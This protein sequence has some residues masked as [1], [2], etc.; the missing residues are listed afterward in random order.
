ML[1]QE[2]TARR[3]LIPGRRPIRHHPDLP[4]PNMLRP[5]LGFA[6]FAAAWLMPAE[7]APN[8]IYILADDLGYGDLGC[9][10]QQK[11]STPNIDRLAREGMRFTSFYAGNTVCAPSRS[12]LLTGQHTGHTSIRGNAEVMP[13]GQE[14]LPADTLTI[15]EVLRPAGYTSGAFGKWGLGFV[16]TEGDPQAQGFDRFF[17]YNCQRFAHRYFPPYLWD[18][19]RQVFLPGNDM[20]S[21]TTYAPDVLHDEMLGFIRTHAS[22][23]FFLFVATPIPHAELAAP[24]DEILAQFKGKFPEVPFPGWNGVWGGEAAY[25]PNAAPGGY[26]PQA[27]PRATFAAMVTR[28]DRQVGDLLRLLDELGIAD[29]TLV[30]FTSDNGPHVEGGHEESFFDSNGPFRGH[31]RDMYEG[32]IRVPMIARW[33]GRIAAGRIVD[34]PFAAWDIL[35]TLS[36][37]AGV[38]P[39]VGVDGLSM[40]P[41]LL[42]RPGQQRHEYLYWE[43]SEGRPVQAVRAGDWKAIHTFADKE[44]PARTELYNLAADPGETTN[45]AAEEPLVT[46]RLRRYMAEAHRFNARFPLPIDR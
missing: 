8:I 27:T 26:A 2:P 44:R 30:I 11:F 16:G 31:K 43:F 19:T 1:L 17:G 40:V 38:N 41:I 35:P 28:L 24:D 22:G 36:E 12:A 45:L 33:P 21:T 46:E 13:E 5:F 23:P 18:G 25:G 7:G 34:Q 29:N 37:L 32:G 14:P 15:P 6:L 3:A 39:P 4:F 9:Y 42:G 20:R 10:G